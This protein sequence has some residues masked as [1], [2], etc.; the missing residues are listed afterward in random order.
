MVEK[1]DLV[2]RLKRGE[3]IESINEVYS[4]L[5]QL[6]NEYNCKFRYDEFESTFFINNNL[7]F[8][9]RHIIHVECD[10]YNVTLNL[11]GLTH[12]KVSRFTLKAK[13]TLGR[14]PDVD[15]IELFKLIIEKRN[16]VKKEK[17]TCSYVFN[18]ILKPLM[19]SD[20]YLRSKRVKDHLKFI[21]ALKGKNPSIWLHI[22]TDKHIEIIKEKLREQKN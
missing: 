16:K 19:K 18:Y 6:A 22:I 2:S 4:K 1:K 21:P 14:K 10:R 8:E 12:F 17:F 7:S 20:G 11:H 13:K 3:R 15:V 5:N 9:D